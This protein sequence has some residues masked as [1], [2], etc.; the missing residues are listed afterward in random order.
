MIDSYMGTLEQKPISWSNQGT[1]EN[2]I[3]SSCID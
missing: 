1:Q 2:S 3:G